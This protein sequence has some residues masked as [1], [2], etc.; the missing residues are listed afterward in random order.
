M[1]LPRIDCIVGARPNF[2]KIAPI[3]RALD[4]ADIRLVHTGQ[5]YDVAMNSVFFEELGIP[6]PDINLEVGSDSNTSQTAR[7]MMG[8]ETV[9]TEN[10]PDMVLVVG[11]VNSTMAAALVAA[12]LTIPVTHV[13][14]GL[15]SNDRT[16]PEEI[17]RLVTD[18]LSDLLLTADRAAVDQLIAEGAPTDSIHFVGNVMIDTMRACLDRA[19]PPEAT[20]MEHGADAA[21]VAAARGGFGLVTLHRPSNVDDEAQLRRLLDVLGELS[22]DLPLVFAVHPRTMAR[23]EAFGLASRGRILTTPPLSY[24]R[25]LGLMRAARLVIT[26]SG[27]IQEETTALGVPCLTVRENTERP[28]T[29]TEGTNVVVGASA[30]GLRRAAR[31]TLANGGKRG[32]V[33]EFWDGRAAERIAER[34][35]AFLARRTSASAT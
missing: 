19:V 12:K 7:I 22:G 17:N 28:I 4:F 20:L 5:H 29:V 21:F 23:I 24:L 27:G 11:D 18:R 34:V 6:D 1:Y 25:N 9:F 33:P 15:R 35:H 26:D 2:V 14:A 32:N 13:E 3:A 16:M 10:R 31:E 30:D 8:L